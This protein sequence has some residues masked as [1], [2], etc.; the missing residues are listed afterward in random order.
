MSKKVKLYAVITGESTKE[1]IGGLCRIGELLGQGAQGCRKISEEDGN[2]Y[3]Y[4][5]EP[6]SEEEEAK[7][8]K[9]KTDEKIESKVEINVKKNKKK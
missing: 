7:V 5:I 2:M 6:F 1:L 4:H 8:E 9:K 3:A